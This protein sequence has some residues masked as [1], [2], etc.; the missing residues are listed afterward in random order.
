MKCDRKIPENEERYWFRLGVQSRTVFSS[1]ELLLL[2]SFECEDI[3][4]YNGNSYGKIRSDLLVNV[5]ITEGHKAENIETN[6]DTNILM[7]MKAELGSKNACVSLAQPILINPGFFYSI[8]INKFPDEHFVHCRE[9]KR[10]VELDSNITVEFYNSLINDGKTFQAISA[11]K[12][13][14]I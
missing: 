4:F 1:T 10:K 9:L 3:G 12:F 2:G 6:A 11:L 13:N 5:K 7:T 8:C 14:K